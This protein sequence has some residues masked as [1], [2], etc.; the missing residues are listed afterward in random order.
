[1]SSSYFKDKENELIK[2]EKLKNFYAEENK[3]KLFFDSF[4]E[5]FYFPEVAT[6][7]QKVLLNALE[8]EK[9]ISSYQTDLYDPDEMK[10]VHKEYSTVEEKNS[11]IESYQTFI[12]QIYQII[13]KEAEAVKYIKD[14]KN[15]IVTLPK[16]NNS[17]YLETEIEIQKYSGAQKLY[18]AFVK[19]KTF[20]TYFN[21]TSL[22]K[23]PKLAQF[24]KDY[25]EAS[26]EITKKTTAHVL[27]DTFDLETKKQG[28]WS[29]G[30]LAVRNE[31][32][33][34]LKNAIENRF[35]ELLK[36]SKTSQPGD[37]NN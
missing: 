14:N 29:F 17:K 30:S 18:N 1:M 24:M 26:I 10:I 33:N 31:F 9:Q 19:G 13:L 37:E 21:K 34:K 5:L 22:L 2:S 27:K 23:Y 8:Q 15:N 12:L 4:A 6:E 32:L 20:D 16:L 11:A 3:F 28:N 35:E 25:L 36:N 7:M